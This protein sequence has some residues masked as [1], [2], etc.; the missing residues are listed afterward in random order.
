M[1]SDSELLAKA[2]IFF[3]EHVQPNAEA[4]DGD[5]EALRIAL[6]E[7]CRQEL[8]A[9]RR[10]A[11]Y[12]GPGIGEQA[13]RQFQE[14]SARY[15][16]ALSFLMTQHQS[17]VGMLAKSDNQELKNDYLPKMANGELL[18]GI[19]FSQLR[20]TG[21][22]ITGAIPVEGGYQIDGQAPWIT[23]FGFYHQFLIGATLPDGSAVY[24]FAPF[25]ESEQ[26]HFSEPMKL[27]AMEA[28]QTVSAILNNLFL[29]YEKVVFIKP[30]GWAN[31]N[32][33][34][35]IV[36][37]G[38]FALGCAQAGVDQVRSAFE[39]KPIEAIRE[40][41]GRLQAELDA[42]RIA[43]TAIPA[44][45]DAETTPEKL[46]IRAWAIQLAAKCAHS[47]V[48]AWGGAAISTKHPAQRIFRE[49]MVYSVSAQTSDILEA[50]LSRIS[51]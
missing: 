42:C 8:M 48:I 26:I 2:E 34:I 28:A 7:M 19:G 11:E 35:N 29:P 32:D 13:F 39:K 27:A 40:T 47:G 25:V 9:L 45:I 14:M 36:L 23:G 10:P 38:H 22:P 5:P 43:A 15:S 6:N 37:Q 41:A 1:G 50:S 51:M 31:K 21:P 24:G 12:G 44:D 33:M 30:E 16:G 18:S 17:A 49:A 3:L 4:M 46:R 20:R